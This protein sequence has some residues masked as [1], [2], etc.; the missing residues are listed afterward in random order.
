[1]LKYY[2]MVIIK[3]H[4]LKYQFKKGFFKT[5]IMYFMFQGMMNQS[6]MFKK[7]AMENLNALLSKFSLLQL[8]SVQ[9]QKT[10]KQDLFFIVT[11]IYFS[12]LQITRRFSHRGGN[13]GRSNRFREEERSCNS[14]C[15]GGLQAPGQNGA[16]KGSNSW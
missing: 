5:F 9:S 12:S 15:F 1:M 11:C 8:I 14:V 3:A 7:M 2:Y 16:T 13:G 6:T 10:L 4:I